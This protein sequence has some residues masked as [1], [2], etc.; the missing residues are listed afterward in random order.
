VEFLVADATRDFYFLEMNTRLQVEH[1]VT[2]LV[3]GFDLVREQFRVANG[4]KLSFTQ[5]D[6]EWHGH[7]IEC[8]IYA[9]D[10]AN[11]FFPSP[12][13]IT[14]LQEPSGPGIRVDSGVRLHSKV[15]THYDPMVAKL[16]G[17]S[18]RSAGTCARR[19]FH[20]WYHDYTFVF[21]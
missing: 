9:E 5:E 14:Y 13:V 18:Y 1:P 17:G 19:V 15:S 16:A 12:G 11:S 21:P 3:T 10:P 2:E 20:L 4:E 6:I 8:R 7:A